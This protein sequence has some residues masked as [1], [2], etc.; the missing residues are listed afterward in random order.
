MISEKLVKAVNDQI[1]KEIYSSNLYLS[2][3]GYFHSISLTGMASWMRNQSKEELMH[4]HKL[5]DFVLT[6]G[7]LPK[8]GKI[9]TPPNEW[10]NALDGFKDALAHE[11]FVTKSI[12]DLTLL[13]QKEKDLPLEVLLHWFINEQV[14]EEATVQEL[15]DRLTIAADSPGGLFIID[16]ELRNKPATT[17]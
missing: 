16:S 12:N 13:A 3:S 17:V 8:I 2:M 11:K 15:V 10:K 7:G 9:D 5:F 4:A 14:E 6:R 1:T